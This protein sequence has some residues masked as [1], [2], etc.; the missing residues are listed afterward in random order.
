MTRGSFLAAA[1]VPLSLLLAAGCSNPPAVQQADQPATTICG[2]CRV[3]TSGG[4]AGGGG[5]R[6]PA[7]EEGVKVIVRD[8]RGKRTIT[9]T[10]SGKGGEYKLALAPGKYE[11]E[12]VL[13]KGLLCD[14]CR[15]LVE[16]KP[17]E[18]ARVDLDLYVIQP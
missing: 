11:V 12:A 7:P 2:V 4:P 3:G 14:Y 9:E 10:T 18:V 8:S 5:Q 17:G 6:H 15:R 1:V 13:Q 16:V